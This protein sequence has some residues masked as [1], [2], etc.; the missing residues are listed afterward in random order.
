M[1]AVYEDTDALDVTAEVVITNPAVPFCGLVRMADD[2]RIT[3][4]CDVGGPAAECALAVTDM[5]VPLLIHG[6]ENMR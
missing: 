2:A 4:Q 1:M 5:I 3:R 6:A